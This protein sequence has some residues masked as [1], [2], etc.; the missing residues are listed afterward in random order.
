MLYLQH[1]KQNDEEMSTQKQIKTPKPRAK[2]YEEKL[3]IDASFLD[4]IRIAVK[5]PK[6]KS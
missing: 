3:A 2:K 1:Q 4:V 6:H 5:S